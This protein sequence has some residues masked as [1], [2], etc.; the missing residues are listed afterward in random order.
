MPNQIPSPLVTVVCTVFNH[1][2]YLK[3]CLDGFV[4]Q[5]T[6]FPFIVLVHDDCS[7]DD[8]V[9]IIKEYAD[10]YPNIIIP[11][12]ET[13]NQYSKHDGSLMRAIDVHIKSK[14][15]AYCE[16]DDFWTSP[17]K[18]QV[19]VDYMERHPDCALCFHDVDIL[20]KGKPASGKKLY[21]HLHEGQFTGDEIIRRWTVP[22]CSAMMRSAHYL[23]RPYDR[24]FAVGDNVMWLNSLQYGYAYCIFKKM[25]TYRRIESGWT[26]DE[27]SGDKSKVAKAYER[28]VRHLKLLKHYFPNVADNGISDYITEYYTRLAIVYASTLNMKFF[29]SI[30][31]GIKIG[32]FG[33]FSQFMKTALF[34]IQVRAKKI[35]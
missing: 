9:R 10:K 34:Y 18:L 6:D 35:L 33:Y 11:I 30:R 22:T 7:T 1:G 13:E 8:S 29:A 23:S 31:N 19:Q 20:Y 12:I 15:V 5:K 14:Y 32:G 16:G 27:F 28:Q 25:A 26:L 4:M 17:Q 24:N 3:S 21:A 2:K